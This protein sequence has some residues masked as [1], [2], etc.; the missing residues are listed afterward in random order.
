MAF[1]LRAYIQVGNITTQ[2]SLLGCTASSLA[3]V[4]FHPCFHRALRGY[5][6][7]SASLTKKTTKG[8]RKDDRTH[9]QPSSRKAPRTPKM[10]IS[11][12][13][14]T[15]AT[16]TVTVE[17][18][19]VQNLNPLKLTEEQ[20]KELDRM[21]VKAQFMPT[22]DPWGQEVRDTLGRS[23]RLLSHLFMFYNIIVQDVMIPYNVNYKSFTRETYKQIKRNLTNS[24]K[25]AAACVSGS[26]FYFP[27]NFLH[28]CFCRL[29]SL[30]S[31]NSVPGVTTLHEKSLGQK[32][33][34]VKQIFST[35]SVKP[36]SLVAPFRQ[37]ALDLYMHM[38]DTIARFVI[39]MLSTFFLYSHYRHPSSRRNEKDL[40]K[41]TTFSYQKHALE[42]LKTYKTKLANTSLFWQMHREYEPTRI[43]SLRVI[44]GHLG[45][46]EPKFG[47]RLMVHALLKF[48][49][50]QVRLV[51]TAFQDLI[52]LQTRV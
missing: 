52:F 41:I 11:S 31:A 38:N 8:T 45:D 47:N 17:H 23:L 48:D 6:A 28:L 51:P 39:Y 29:S 19:K 21:I 5:A 35:Q 49:T 12:K 37:I 16:D 2:N 14:E 24:F 20:T 26:L 15:A 32:I 10:T 30:A 44:Q 1:K 27:L 33:R 3:R 18:S 4:Q 46:E 9:P 7:T 22:M 50:E 40:I 42:M 43:L 13:T 36:D 25:N 34:D